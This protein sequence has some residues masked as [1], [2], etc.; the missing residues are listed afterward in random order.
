MLLKHYVFP[1]VKTNVLL[2]YVALE[3]FN[4]GNL[5]YQLS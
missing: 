5:H 3:T 2:K 1:C 4:G